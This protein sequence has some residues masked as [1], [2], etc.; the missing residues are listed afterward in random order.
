MKTVSNNSAAHITNVSS[1]IFPAS[2]IDTVSIYYNSLKHLLR[3]KIKK[4]YFEI[5]T[6]FTIPLQK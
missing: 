3:Y 1:S 5:A 4:T 2:L 6:V